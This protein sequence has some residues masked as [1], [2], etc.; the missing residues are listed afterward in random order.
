MNYSCWF[1]GSYTWQGWN[2]HGNAVAGAVV[3]TANHT[4]LNI[5]KHVGHGSANVAEFGAASLVLE[6]LL[7][8]PVGQAVVKGDSKIVVNCLRKSKPAKGLCHDA[9]IKAITLLSCLLTQGWKVDLCWVPCG[10]NT[11][12]DALSKSLFPL[13]H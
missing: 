4:L 10:L 3:R 11:E 1:D 6:H 5:T 7:T 9:S 12:C 13:T 2:T 8:L